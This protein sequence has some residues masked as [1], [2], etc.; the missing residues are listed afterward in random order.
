MTE[1]KV[2]LHPSWQRLHQQSIQ[3]V[4]QISAHL[5]VIIFRGK[6]PLVLT[7]DFDNLHPSFSFENMEAKINLEAWKPHP[8]T[9]IL[10]GG[11]INTIQ[12]DEFHR[13]ELQ[14]TLD[15]K[16]FTWVIQLAPYAP[17]FFF[18]QHDTLLFD[19]IVGWHSSK[20]IL[21]KLSPIHE[22]A[23][24]P[25]H[26]IL[27]HALATTYL[28]IIQQTYQKK[29]R[30]KE[31]L[32]NDLMMHQRHL[33][34]QGLA[35]AIQQQ[36][37]LPW[38]QYENPQKLPIPSPT[39]QTDF[40]GVNLLYRLYKKAKQGTKEVSLQQQANDQTIAELNMFL[41][42]Q[43]PLSS[44]EILQLKTYLVNH[45]LLS[46]QSEKPIPVHQRSPYFVE[47]KGIRFSFGKN[48]KQND[49]LTF[50]IAKKS[51]IFMH[52]QGKPGAHLIIHH[53]E[54]DHD[55]LIKGG[56]LVLALAQQLSGTI[57]YAKVG[58]LKRTRNLGEVIMKDAKT[59][60]IN[61][62]PIWAEA[63]L[64]NAKRY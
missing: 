4:Y 57:T 52:I 62:D 6:P 27:Q 37:S 41:K 46:G 15:D 10:K 64:A 3:F 20:K 14:L 26:T 9:S 22:P 58:S 19:S 59:L 31:A 63:L 11:K 54:F 8:L 32:A 5:W 34:Y 51:D 55:L 39:F 56:Q 16:T 43:P 23:N 18:L 50:E 36:P 2:L 45:H 53:R 42:L 47:E 33:G 61:A 28:S 17:R 13:I 40:N 30:R 25:L 7:L 12:Q 38:E 49:Q 1:T 24:Q 44:S 60:K 48:A 35:E 21:P 29:L